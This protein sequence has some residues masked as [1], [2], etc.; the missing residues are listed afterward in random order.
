M[1]NNPTT[2]RL[3]PG[4]PVTLRAVGFL[5]G[6]GELNAGP[7]FDGLNIEAERAL[8][9]RM[10]YWLSGNNS[11]SKWFHGFP[12]D[13]DHKN[14]FVFKYQERRFYGFLCHPMPKT[15]PRL[16]LCVL[17]I[18]ATKNEWETDKAELDRVKEWL[19]GMASIG[20]IQYLYLEYGKQEP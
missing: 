12:N 5:E 4:L 11:P 9:A 8:K 17:C 6:H 7:V 16:Q 19:I 1:A 13:K 3:V 18:H 10:N 2:F 20:T 14:C 15:K